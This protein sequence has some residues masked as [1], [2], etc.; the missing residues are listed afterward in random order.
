MKFED[1]LGDLR[2][3]SLA[4]LSD[5]PGTFYAYKNNKLVQIV[6]KIEQE[7]IQ[8]ENYLQ[9]NGW[10][11]V[12]PLSASASVSLQDLETAW[13]SL[14]VPNS[15][16]GNSETSAAFYAFAQQIGFQNVLP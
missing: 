6:E 13:D 15:S 9:S 8:I 3:G 7:F 2:T 16:F 5:L 4:T 14:I 10:Q 12:T 11:L 1:V